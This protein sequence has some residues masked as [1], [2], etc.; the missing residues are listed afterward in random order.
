MG[1]EIMLIILGVVLLA[2]A[3]FLIPVL[4]QIKRT[5]KNL[6]E[7]LLQINGGLPLIIRN[8]QEITTNVNQ[9]T[10]AVNVQVAELSL[11]L[12]RIQ[13]VIGVA[14]GL[15]EAIRHRVASPFSRT[16]RTSLALVRG[17]RVFVECLTGG[18]GEERETK[19]LRPR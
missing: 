15:E 19:I 10:T 13:A 7:T 11:T 9:A 8:I 14:L 5:A 17:I 16:I 2:I 3:G 12:R 4:I 18:K 1:T 6:N